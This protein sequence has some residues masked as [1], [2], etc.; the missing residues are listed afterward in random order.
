MDDF[1][2]GSDICEEAGLTDEARFLQSV[3]NQTAKVFV[4]VERGF[5]YNDEIYE[6]EEDAAPRH[7]FLDKES[8]RREAEFR[9]VDQ[10]RTVNPLA[11]CYE[12]AEVCSLDA[13]QLQERIANI[14]GS[15]YQLPGEDGFWEL[16]PIFP[17]SAS[18]DQLREIF[19]LFD[20]L[21][22]FEV[23]EADVSV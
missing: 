9:N 12:L 8:A 4:V 1:Q 13:E 2:I 17:P 7:V 16:D 18:D 19:K 20:R 6:L 3:S 10:L 23:I 15:D 11:F 22:F 14:L 21:D 5:E